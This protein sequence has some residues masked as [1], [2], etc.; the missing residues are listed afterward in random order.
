MANKSFKKASQVEEQILKIKELQRQQ[1]A[2]DEDIK[3]LK[4]E[5]KEFMDKEGL[6]EL[7]GTDHRV[8]YSEVV[9]ELF[10]AKLFAKEHE[11]LYIKYLYTSTSKPFN[12]Y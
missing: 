10:N 11:K 1:K 7:A 6:E 5:L 3:V 8:V 2:L 4:D 12:I 9:K